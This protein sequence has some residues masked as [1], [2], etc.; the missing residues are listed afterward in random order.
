MP[1]DPNDLRVLA[2]SAK[3]YRLVAEPDTEALGLVV[4]GWSEPGAQHVLW[5]VRTGAAELEVTARLQRV[6]DPLLAGEP[7]TVVPA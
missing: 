2:A 7:V 4:E 6:G 5:L 3:L 1:D